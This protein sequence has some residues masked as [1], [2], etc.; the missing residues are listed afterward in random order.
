MFS[1]QSIK[2]F[3]KPNKK[4]ILVFVILFVATIF[5]GF[6][7]TSQTPSSFSDEDETIIIDQRTC[8]TEGIF[9]PL[10]RPFSFVIG[11]LIKGFIFNGDIVLC[12]ADIIS[13]LFFPIDIICLYLLSC[14][15]IFVYNRTKPKPKKIIKFI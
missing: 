2:Q 3:L 5:V 8:G 10:L 15:V 12:G 9:N 4:K 14:F 7:N 11:N 1:K 13:S 6:I